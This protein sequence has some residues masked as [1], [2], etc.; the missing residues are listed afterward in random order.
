VLLDV[1]AVRYFAEQLTG[2]L[3]RDPSVRTVANLVATVS[4][5]TLNSSDAINTSNQSLVM[6]GLFVCG[7]E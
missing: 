6:T 3:G 1:S 2:E 4:S 7:Q 5:L